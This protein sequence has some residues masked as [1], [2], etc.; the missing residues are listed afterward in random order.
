M[1]VLNFGSLNIDMVY[2]V[3]HVSRPGA[4][5]SIPT[6]DKVKSFLEERGE[7]LL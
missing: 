6:L 1:K 4:Y 5:A 2:S 7:N 3:D